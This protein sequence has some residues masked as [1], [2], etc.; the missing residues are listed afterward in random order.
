MSDVETDRVQLGGYP[1]APRRA[2]DW[3][4]RGP[5]YPVFPHLGHFVDRTGHLGNSVVRQLGRFQ[6][7]I[8]AGVTHSRELHFWE[9][10]KA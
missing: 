8:P 2:L 6:M 9:F 5:E 10:P 4:S 7:L 3:F 1:K